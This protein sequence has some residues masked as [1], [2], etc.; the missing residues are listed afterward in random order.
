IWEALEGNTCDLDSIWEETG[1]DYNFTPSGFKDALTVSR[2]DVAIPSDAV[3]AYK[4]QRQE[5]CD[6]VR[7]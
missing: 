3:R 2:D 4:R 7:T 5:L 1:Q 6:G